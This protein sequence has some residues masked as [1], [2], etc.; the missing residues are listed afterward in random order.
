MLPFSRSTGHLELMT[1]NH[2]LTNVELPPAENSMADT[3]VRSA[4]EGK[5]LSG[6]R[7][8]VMLGL[9]VA[10]SLAVRMA[11]WAYWG[12]G[13]IESEGAEYTRIAENLRNGL[14]YVGIVSP[15]PQLVFNPLFP[16]LIAGASF[17]TPD[18]ERAA[19]LVVLLFGALLPLP[20]FGIASRLFNRRVGF[21]AAALTMLF[22]MLVSLSFSV[23]SEGPYTTLFLTAAYLVVRALDHP[24]LKLWCLVGGVFGLAYLVRQEAIAALLISILFAL[25]A[26]EGPAAIRC[27]RAAA[28]LTVFVALALPQVVFIYRSTGKIRL[29]GKSAQF[30]A[31]GK[32]ILAAEATPPVPQRSSDGELDV[33]SPLPSVPSWETWQEKWAF[34]AIDAHL[35][36]TGVAL[37]SHTEVVRQTKIRLADLFHLVGKGVREN[38]PQLIGQLSERLLGGPFLLALA[39]LGAFRRPWRRSK[40]TTRLFVMVIAA[41]PVLATFTALWTQTRYYF[42]LVPFLLIWAANGLVGIGLWAKASSAAAGWRA[43]ARPVVSEGIIPAIIG[44]AVVV[45]P[46]KGVRSNSFF[47]LGSP[48]TQVEKDVGLWISQRQHQTRIMDLSIPLSFYANATW[49]HFPYC[50]GDL[51]L[52][53]LDAAQV[54]YI[55]LRHETFTKYY[56]D[57]LE[58]GVPD[59]RAEL[60]HVSPAA[61]AQFVVYRW[62]RAGEAGF[63]K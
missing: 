23:F 26:T 36:R 43:L 33:P 42:V 46:A 50:N 41:A 57:W 31:L 62:H 4:R 56:Q 63:G 30:F 45:Y 24:S 40:A 16:L 14:G 59:R 44:L 2:L 39:L 58:H 53:F 5:G 49:V 37:Q 38:A 54:D 18:Y 32:R 28:A 22:P 20:V 52:R 29:D 1:V 27:K 19:R 55:V 48:S 11:A 35:N 60:L 17:I 12:T 3:G 51:A 34:Y 6:R 15:G 25:A 7:L 8:F 9:L 21:I 13:A 10:A 47:T 61:D